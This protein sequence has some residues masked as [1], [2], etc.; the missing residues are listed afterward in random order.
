MHAR[1]S[2]ARSRITLAHLVM[3]AATGGLL[4]LSAGAAC[5]DEDIWPSL[6]SDIFETRPLIE[7]DG[8]VQIDAPY[9]AE[10]AAVVP[11]T[12]RVSPEVKGQLKSMT[13][14]IDKNPSPVAA[15][16]TFGPGAGK[17]G[18]ERRMTTRVRIDTYSNVRAVVETEDGKLHMAKAFVKASGGCSAPAPKD[19]DNDLAGLGK[20][21]VKS[22]DPAPPQTAL[23]EGIVMIRHP[24]NNGM[25]MDQVTRSYIPAR[26]IRE[27]TVMRGK[28]LVFRAETGI[29]ISTNPHFRFTYINAP[30]SSLDVAAIDTDDT[31][32]TGHSAKK[33]A[34]Q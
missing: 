5:A 12:I 30:D 11:I 6:K 22:I 4:M 23:R 7:N 14:I 25:Q 28:D 33:T 18:A 31:R 19:A 15:A 3:A 34:S 1:R 8:V 21:I 20:T 29:S 13:L 10:D 17:G 16:F 2:A 27:I 26:F 32:F 24:N 9:R